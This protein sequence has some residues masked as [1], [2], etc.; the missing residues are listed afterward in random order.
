MSNSQHI[1]HSAISILTQYCPTDRITQSRNLAWFITGLVVAAHCQLTRIAP[2][3]PWDGERD[4]VI[5]R[6]RRIVMNPRLEV[7]TLYGPTV[8]YLLHWLN[9]PG[10]LVL[11]ID[12]TTLSNDLNILMI[13]IAFR[14]RVLPLAWKVQKKQGSFQRRYVEAALRFIAQ[15]TP[16]HAQM[17]VVG[18]REYQDVALHSFVRD[19]LGWHFVQRLD[20]RTWVFPAR[21]GRFKLNA[22]GLKP[23][24]YRS[25]GRVRITQ[26]RFGWVELIGYWAPD[27]DEPWYL[28]SDR[29][30]GRH[31]VR[32]YRK[33]FWIEEMFRDFK[34]HGWDLERSGLLHP[35]RMQRLL[36]LIAFAYV[37]LVNIGVQVVKRGLRAWVDRRARRTLSYFRLGWNWLNRMLA[38]NGPLPT[39][40]ITPSYAK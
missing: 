17:W 7:R 15:G 28:I 33:R 23:G 26:Q 37:W 25:F 9:G 11:V 14:G 32:L 30:L 6:L 34:S 36:L 27:E 8:G 10:G 5:Q 12:R 2:H 13:G 38:R 19:T 1:Y 4:S 18:D 31:Q 35:Q 21:G 29:T 24:Q 20:Q 40:I 39:L 22:S 3:L 16:L